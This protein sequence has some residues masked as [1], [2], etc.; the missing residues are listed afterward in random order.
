MVGMGNRSIQVAG[1]L[2]RYRRL[3]VVLAQLG[4]IVVSYLASFFL[5][6][7]LNAG[8]IPW[9]VVLKTLPLLV[10]VR[11][12]ALALFRLYHGLWRY[13]SVV[14]LLQIIKAVTLGSLAF[15]ALEILIFGLEGFPRSVFFLDWMGAIFL[16]SGIRL[17]VRLARERFG[18]RSAEDGGRAPQRILIIGAGDVGAELCRQALTNRAARLR[19]VAFVDEDRNKARTSILGIPIAGRYEDIS[20]VVGEYRV[21]MAVLAIPDARP[22]DRRSVVE[23]CQKGG[24][25]SGYSPP[26]QTCWRA[27]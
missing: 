12:S 3:V 4:L 25:R 23:L 26:S 20:R 17:F 19:P 6:L 7:D 11:M 5:R 16:L 1:L 10:V 13:V 24:S 27:R 8:E 22:Q 18:I 9:S 15:A 2:P 14:D 21:D